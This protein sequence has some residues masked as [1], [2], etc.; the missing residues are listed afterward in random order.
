[1]SL[2]GGLAGNGRP[3]LLATQMWADDVNARGGLLGR[4]VELVFYDDQSM[5]AN[6]PGIYTKLLDVDKVDL[7]VSGYGTAIIAPAMPV[8]MQHGAAFVTL[9]GSAT[10]AEF[11]YDRC[12]NVSP[13]GGK[14][15]E[16]FAKGFFEIAKGIT[17]RPKTVSIAGLDSD[18]PMRAM[19]SA[20]TQAGAAGLSIVYDSA[21]PPS[22]V[23]YSPIIRAIQAAKP[24]LV[25]FASYP[26][27]SIGLLKAAREL[28][29]TAMML[30]G[31]MIGPQVTGIKQQLGA[32]LNNLVC[33]DVY[34]PEPTMNFP[35]IASF[36]DRY[37][38]AAAEQKGGNPRALCPSTRLCPNAGS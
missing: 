35:G 22:T 1:M 29:L 33:W 28:K 20:R 15:E 37:R 19:Q 13:V 5:G 24:D 12:A 31:G 25:F 10:N 8:V 32:S 6:V 7:V 21:Y 34:A 16:D 17:P 18:F 11:K 4:R 30:G 36:L 27:D 23:D 26:P 14:M 3:S 9:L 2:S 38:A